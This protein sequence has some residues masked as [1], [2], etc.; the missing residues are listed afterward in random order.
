MRHGLVE[1]GFKI[2]K[3]FEAKGTV[4]PRPFVKNFD[5]FKDG[6]LDI[7]LKHYFQPEHEA[8]R[9]ALQMVTPK[10]LTNGQKSPKEEMVETL[11]N[12]GQN[13][14]EKQDSLGTNIESIIILYYLA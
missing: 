9:H 11:K 4:E 6:G 7:V 12:N 14:E 10:L 5:P 8:F 3:G 2:P 13:R 1:V